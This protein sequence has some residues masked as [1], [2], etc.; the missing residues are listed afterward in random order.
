MQSTGAPRT[1]NA[2]W[3]DREVDEQG[4]RLRKDVRKAGHEV[5]GSVRRYVAVILGDDSDAA[6]FLEAAVH[7]I[8][9]YLD[10][11]RARLFSTNA[12]AL[13]MSAV[14]SAL[15][16]Q[17]SKRRREKAV[18]GSSDLAP[19]LLAP[20]WRDKVEPH[21][22]LQKVTSGFSKLARDVLALRLEGY[23]WKQ[24]SEHLGVAVPVA[25]RSVQR[26]LPKARAMVTGNHSNGPSSTEG[27]RV[28]VIHP[29]EPRK[30]V[31][32]YH[33]LFRR[34]MLPPKA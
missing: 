17:A 32:S 33:Q 34:G 5:W 19:C 10:R 21:L 25:K 9:D 20:D 14:R 7:D 16:R 27:S 24:V 13:I 31:I 2:V 26:E 30:K 22:D 23:R 15:R 28:T 18:G 12:A 3:W 1:T 8:S 29:G 11:Q 6:Q 4:H